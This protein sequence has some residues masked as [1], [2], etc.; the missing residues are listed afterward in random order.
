MGNRLWR[1]VVLLPLALANGD[2]AGKPDVAL[3][4][5]R[6]FGYKAPRLDEFP[7]ARFTQTSPH[8]EL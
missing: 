6:D 7:L 8:R 3:G 5:P 1:L 2:T 4:L